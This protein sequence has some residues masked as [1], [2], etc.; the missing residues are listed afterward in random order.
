MY[1]THVYE[2]CEVLILCNLRIKYGNYD[3]ET[4]PEAEIE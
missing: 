1:I 4:F 3:E 2:V